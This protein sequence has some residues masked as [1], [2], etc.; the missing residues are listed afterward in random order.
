MFVDLGLPII[1]VDL[2]ETF[3]EANSTMSNPWPC[4]NNVNVDI[5]P[6]VICNGSVK[7]ARF[8]RITIPQNNVKLTLCEVEV[9]GRRGEITFYHLIHSESRC[10]S[11]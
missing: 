11:I 5:N 4:K 2:G 3:A 9:Y 8:V 6:E 7:A 10:W 1:N